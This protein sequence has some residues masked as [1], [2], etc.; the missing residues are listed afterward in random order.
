MDMCGGMQINSNNSKNN[1]EN[2]DNNKDTFRVIYLGNCSTGRS[3]GGACYSPLRVSQTV[4]TG[5]HGYGM[6]NVCI[7]MN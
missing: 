2:K 6:G 5:T 7:T 1:K 3:E 4:T